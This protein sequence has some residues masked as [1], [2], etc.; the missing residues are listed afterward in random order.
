MEMRCN[1][2][3]ERDKER[4]QLTDHS[5]C[6][7]QRSSLKEDSWDGERCNSRNELSCGWEMVRRTGRQFLWLSVIA[8]TQ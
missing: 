8:V 3:S 1:G 4:F 7:W 2:M 6:S 5:C